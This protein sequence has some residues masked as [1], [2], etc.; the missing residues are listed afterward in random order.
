[1]KIIRLATVS[2]IA[3]GLSLSGCGSK[4][5]SKKAEDPAAGT[6]GEQEINAL[7]DVD[8]AGSNGLALI[9]TSATWSGSV[10]GCIS[11]RSRSFSQASSSVAVLVGDTGCYAKLD[12]ITVDFGDGSPA[13]TY[14]PDSAY[15]FVA[16][17]S[18]IVSSASSQRLMRISVSTQLPA[19]IVASP[20]PSIAISLGFV[21]AGGTQAASV[22]SASAG[23]NVS[24]GNVIPYQLA[25]TD[26]IVHGATGGG[27]FDFYMNCY[28]VVGADGRCETMDQSGLDGAL[29]LDTY[30]TAGNP[31]DLTIDECT[32]L[33]TGASSAGPTATFL[34]SDNNALLPNGG[35]VLSAIGPATL[36]D[37]ANSKLVLA[38][39]HSATASCKWWRI[40][41][42]CP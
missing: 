12:S 36:C 27:D 18:L 2:V 32:N 9:A 34:D 8:V 14:V 39:A 29:A 21:D 3:A 11:G 22:R 31:R 25:S 16:G 6:S 7:L 41:V 10:S 40:T 42:S 19:T 5:K 37:A 28:G 4:S 35:A 24:V 20:A 15:R 38:V 30:L 1:M 26:L 33:A 23:V 13:A 17:T